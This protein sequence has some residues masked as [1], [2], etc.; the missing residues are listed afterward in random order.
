MAALLPAAAQGQRLQDTFALPDVTIAAPLP[1][2]SMVEIVDASL[3]GSAGAA[4]NFENILKVLPGVQSGNELSSQYSVR[5]GSYD[6]NLVFVEGVEIFRPMLARTGQQEGLSF[7]NP[8]M[9]SAAE[10]SIGAFP[11]E[12]GDRMSSVLNVRYKRP[13]AIGGSLE[14]GLLGGAATGSFINGSRNFSGI[15]GLRT[16]RSAY[17]LETLNEKGEY[18]PVFYDAQA[19]FHYDI[20]PEWSVHFF[21][22]YALNLYDFVPAD[23]Q[24]SFAGGLNAVNY[25]SYNEGGQH[26]RFSNALAMATADYRPAGGAVLSFTASAAV[27]DEQERLD[28]LSEYFLTWASKTQDPS[29]F[30]VGG[31]RQHARNSL[32]TTIWQASHKGVWANGLG[33]L[34]WGAQAQFYSISDNIYQWQTLDSAGYMYPPQGRRAADAAVHCGAAFGVW[35][36]VFGVCTAVV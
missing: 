36:A 1:R 31:L 25:M 11:A 28:I 23:R 9:V 6:E 20:K 29:D 32:A 26:S 33:A 3:I 30:D 21:G 13:T 8:Q 15:V 12:F 4:A 22:N 2:R 34:Q 17:L 7:I 16:R 14:G 35:R 18:T 27:M 5:G 19:L 24:T 10:F